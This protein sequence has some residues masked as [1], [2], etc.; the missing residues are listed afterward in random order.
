MPIIEPAIRPPAEAYSFLLQITLGCSA[1]HCSFCG[2]YLGKPF[3]IKPWVEIKSDIDTHALDYPETRKVFLMDGDAL[4]LNSQKLLP[5]LKYLNKKFP[6]L[7]RISTYANDYNILAKTDEELNELYQ[8]KLKLIYMG[9]ESGDQEILDNCQKKS[10]VQGMIQSIKRV[11]AFG[12]KSSVIVLLGLGGKKLSA[13]H[14]LKTAEALNQMQPRY[15]SFLSLM[16]I[17]TTPLY[18]QQQSGEFDELNSLELLEE[19]YAIIEKIELKK[20]IFRSNHASNYLSL[21]GRFPQD[22][23]RLLETLKRA[24]KGNLSLRPEIFRGL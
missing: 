23:D 5:I 9:L 1:N 17:P 14:A 11:Q 3:K 10:K 16:L 19:A 18:K 7:I 4:V 6:K 2:A 20:T 22:K 15:L 21:E 24:L 12:I 8:H 13:R